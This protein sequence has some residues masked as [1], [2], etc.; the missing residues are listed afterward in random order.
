ME[1]RPEVTRE[2]S[3]LKP[4]SHLFGEVKKFAPN[5][6]TATAHAFSCCPIGPLP[7]RNAKHGRNPQALESSTFEQKRF[8]QLS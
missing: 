8:P 2:M 5:P 4:L 1:N 7:M 3:V 6:K